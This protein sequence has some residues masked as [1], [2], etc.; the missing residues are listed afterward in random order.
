MPRAMIIG[1]GP[2]GSI[3]A[4]VLARANWDVH[5]LEQH[6]FPRDKVCGECL[7]PLALEV[8]NELH[9]ASTVCALGAA[10]MSR[11]VLIDPA[12]REAIMQLDSPMCGVSRAALDTALLHAAQ[13]HGVTIH[14]PSRVERIDHHD[15]RITVRDLVTNRIDDR[16][17]DHL[18]IADGKASTLFGPSPTTRDLGIKAHFTSVDD[19]PDAI[20]LFALP[21]HYCGL[22]P[23][24]NGLWNIAM[25]VPAAR[26]RDFQG[27]LDLLWQSILDANPG[28]SR[29]MKPAT[30]ITD[31]L[32]SPLPRFPVRCNWPHH[33][34]PIG[35]AAAALEPI[36][37][38]GM[39]L[40]IKSAQLAANFLQS[41]NQDAS[42]LE[43]EY[44][45][46]WNTRRAV[47]RA[48]A[49]IM[50]NPF[51]AC[52]AIRLLQVNARPGCAFIRWTG[53]PKRKTQPL[54]AI[55]SFSR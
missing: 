3:A 43:R 23:I 4:I 26:V 50:S 38:E 48:G 5:L 14:Q 31:W 16:S 52:F 37:G 41:D 30:R 22:A 2:A 18:L 19:R 24:E 15:Q 21:G 36:G 11:A 46:L 25:S 8:L 6:R 33:V 35:N 17:Y 39:G 10:T 12:G 55:S 34:I 13:Q 45:K 47:C 51:L 20:S 27:N 7:S 28:L 32:A 54:R 53:K 44:H 29:R 42:E 40:A 9:L 49:I 1:A